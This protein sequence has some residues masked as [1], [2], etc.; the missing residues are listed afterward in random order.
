M[1]K[2]ALIL[3]ADSFS[4]Q[5]PFLLSYHFSYTCVFIGYRVFVSRLLRFNFYVPSFVGSASSVPDLVTLRP[6]HKV[7]TTT[8]FDLDLDLYWLT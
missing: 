7:L 4:G 5:F 3:F 8:L 6:E 1:H 2:S